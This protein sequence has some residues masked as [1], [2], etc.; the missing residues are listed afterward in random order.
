MNEKFLQKIVEESDLSEEEVK[1]KISEKMKEYS[2]LV[3]EEGSLHLVARELGI[4]LDKK[5]A[6][7]LKVENIVPGMRKVTL[8]A[9]VANIG[10]T[11]EFDK[12]DGSKGEVRNLVLGDDTGTVRMPLWNEQT[13]IGDKLED[14]DVLEIRNAYSRE[15]NRS[16]VELRIGNTTKI[17]K[18]EEEDFPDVKESSGSGGG[19][20]EKEIID[21]NQENM[22]YSVTGTILDVYTNNPFYKSCP[23]CNRKV[24][25]NEDKFMCDEHGEVEPKNALAIS[26]VI[27]DG[28]DNTRVVFFR[29][30]AQDMLGA[31]EELNEEDEVSKAAEKAIGNKIKI[32]G[33][34]RYNDY[35][36]RV[37]LIANSVEKL[38]T[39]DQIKKM[40]TKLG[41]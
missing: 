24:K 14:G 38:E 27:D 35:F 41:E 25:E 18:V 32:N 17:E 26:A 23:E 10:D 15:D 4:E 22:N 39:E 8:K 5:Q 21:I 40:L 2:G 12:D 9:R 31:E 3:S 28:T 34:T 29:E 1:K 20:E 6:G 16:N 7:E 19:Y 11:R 30:T 33:S 13:E 37:E 36:N